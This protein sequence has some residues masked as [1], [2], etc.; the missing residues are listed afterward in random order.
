M[1]VFEFVNGV[2]EILMRSDHHS[3]SPIMKRGNALL[4]V[5]FE[6]AVEALVVFEFF[7]AE[8]ALPEAVYDC[9]SSFYS[10]S[11]LQ[12]LNCKALGSDILHRFRPFNNL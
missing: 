6:K 4:I 12:R 7:K 10:R 9:A 1:D 2:N 11:Q 3:T 8:A 5:I